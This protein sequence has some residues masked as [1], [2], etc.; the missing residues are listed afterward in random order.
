MATETTGKEEGPLQGPSTSQ[1]RSLENQE[2][3]AV[4]K[5]TA[6]QIP[7]LERTRLVLLPMQLR[8]RP[9]GGVPREW[10]AVSGLGAG[11]THS[12]RGARG[13]TPG[14]QGSDCIISAFPVRSLPK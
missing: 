10:S 12:F 4:Y 6:V 11:N 14:K 1:Q 3:G 8:S 7:R 13:V 9:P 5:G 2:W